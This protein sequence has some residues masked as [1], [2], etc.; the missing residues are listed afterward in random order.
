MSAPKNI[1]LPWQGFAALAAAIAGAVL[2]FAPLD[3]SRPTD[4]EGVPLPAEGEEDVDARLWQDPLAPV[5][6]HEA[7]VQA[8]DATKHPSEFAR[9]EQRHSVETFCR[10]LAEVQAAGDDLVVLAMLMGGGSY[11]EHTEN[12]LRARRA[13]LEALG[14]NELSPSD[15]EHI[16]YVR[17]PLLGSTRFSSTSPGED[18]AGTNAGPEE[19]FLLLYVWYGPAFN[20]RRSA[21]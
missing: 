9:E 10:R 21:A 1:Q 2:Y 14:T 13:V 4:R 8:I 17:V 11:P 12:R 16:G 20:I 5:L 7:Q 18:T 3:T 15:A 19:S 6:G